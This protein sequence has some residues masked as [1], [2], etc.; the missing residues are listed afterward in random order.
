MAWPRKK[1]RKSMDT[2]KDIRRDLRYNPEQDGFRQILKDI[3]RG[4]T[5]NKTERKDCGEKEEIGDFLSTHM[6]KLE[7][8]L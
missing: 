3:K 2:E 6:Y 1:N 4:R 7:M 8:I 5:G